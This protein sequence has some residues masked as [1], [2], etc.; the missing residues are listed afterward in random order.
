MDPITG[1]YKSFGPYDFLEKEAIRFGAEL[2]AYAEDRDKPSEGTIQLLRK[3][4]RTGN[5]TYLL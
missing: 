4:A 1:E 3:T 2:R 5:C